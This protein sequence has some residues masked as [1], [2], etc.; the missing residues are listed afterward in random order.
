MLAMIQVAMRASKHRLQD[1][2]GSMDR[3][4]E[5]YRQVDG[6]EGTLCLN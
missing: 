1:A 3:L 4:M 5:I 6:S 2:A